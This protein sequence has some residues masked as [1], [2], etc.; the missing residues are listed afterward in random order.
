M[1]ALLQC[2]PAAADKTANLAT[3]RRAA[4]LSANFGADILVMPELF[5]TGYN[6]GAQLADLAEPI[7]GPSVQAAR[8][9]AKDTGTA[10]VFG[11][12]ERDGPLVYNT[13][14]A[15][16]RDG[17]VA[18]RYRKIQLFGDREPTIFT[19]GERIEVVA[20]AG[21]R[22]GLA[23][24]YDVEFPELCRAL[25]RAGAELVCVPT[26][27]MLPFVDVPTTLVRARAL[28][29]GVPVVYANLAGEEGDLAYS[30][31]SGIVGF[32][33]RDLAR[34]GEQGE[35]FLACRTAGIRA[36]Q[37]HPMLST[38]VRDL[39]SGALTAR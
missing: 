34:A 20:L 14:I 24:C 35:V 37:A 17:T 30:G 13:A 27:N 33:G 23:I 36:P 29:N 10:L 1:P 18:G 4:I 7:D 28:E 25:K 6:L 32:D 15:I 39:R 5:L 19:P 3:L 9:I 11:L 8:A 38:Q 12:P 26:A 21:L 31:L 16:E 2:L 22:V